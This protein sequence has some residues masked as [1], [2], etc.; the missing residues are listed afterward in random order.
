MDAIAPILPLYIIFLRPLYH[1]IL[2]RPLKIDLIYIHVLLNQNCSLHN[3]FDAKYS[4]IDVYN[5]SYLVYS[6]V[7]N[8]DML[9]TEGF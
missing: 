7:G 9:S 4:E 8:I 3:S 1:K 2:R 5:S 6:S